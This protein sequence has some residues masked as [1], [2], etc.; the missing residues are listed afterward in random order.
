MKCCE[1][2]QKEHE[3]TYGSGRFCSAKCAR[4]FSTKGKRKEINEQVSKKLLNNKIKIIKICPQCLNEFI[5]NPC[6]SHKKCCSC[7]CA[8]KFRGG[9][10]NHDKVDWSKV[11]KKSY[12]KGDRIIAGGLTKWFDYNGIRVQGTY[13]LRTCHI[14]DVWKEYNVIKD[15]EYTKDRVDYIG[16]D[17]KKHSYLLD[18]K[19]FT[20]EGFFYYIEV[21]GYEHPNDPLKWKAVRDKGNKLEVWFEKDILKNEIEYKF[22]V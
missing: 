15:W 11:H 9:W 6:H 13:E 2:C 17:D 1:N 7:S 4:G 14:L 5:V 10:T 22:G 16:E 18:F 8:M 20:N 19:V 3:G 12:A 21:K